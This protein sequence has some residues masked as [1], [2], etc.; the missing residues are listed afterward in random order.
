VIVEKCLKLVSGLG[1]VMLRRGRFTAPKGRKPAE[2]SSRARRS[3][4]QRL[5]ILR[6]GQRACAVIFP[7]PI[8]RVLGA[9]ANKRAVS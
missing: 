4:I 7:L 1:K 6:K 3:R 9:S 5:R 8:A 2:A